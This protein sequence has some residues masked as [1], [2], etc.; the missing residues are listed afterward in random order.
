MLKV[1]ENEQLTPDAKR[2]TLI[3]VHIHDH[4]DIHDTLVSFL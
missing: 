3:N 1:A 4:D 2:P